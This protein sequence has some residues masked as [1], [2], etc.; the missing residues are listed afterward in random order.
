[1][2]N[3]EETLASF[4][5]L[6]GVADNVDLREGRYGRGLFPKDT[7]KPVKI[8]VPNKLLADTEWLQFDT[9]GNLRLS[10]KCGWTDEIKSFYLNYMHVYGLNESLIQQIMRQQSEYAK[11]PETLKSMMTAFGFSADLFKIADRQLCLKI[12]I[13]SRRIVA[14]NKLVMMPLVE[15]VNH[16]EQSKKSFHIEN[17]GVTVSGR[18]KEEILVHYGMVGD[19]ALMY[20]DYGFSTPKPYTFSGALAINLGSKIIR[21]ARFMTLFETIANTNVP[22]L[23]LEGNEIHLSCL[24]IGSVNDRNSPK[25]V[26]IRLMRN[27]GMP[28]HI[29]SS[30]FDGIVDQNRS[31]FLRMLEELKPL[32]GSVVESL[33]IMAK[34]Q[35]L[36]LGI[37]CN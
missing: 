17:N 33:R 25:K 19:A 4:C 37:R 22:K 14:N 7:D 31:F 29:A 24:V 36:P 30:V 15:L 21:V 11:L 8:L 2:N 9:K 18:F 16:E 32:E 35:L 27:V 12:F 20:E 23:K 5:A 3:W 28:D 1:M 6:G 13:R 34:N 26:F 10:D